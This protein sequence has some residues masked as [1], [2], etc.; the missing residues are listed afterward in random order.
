MTEVLITGDSHSAVMLRSLRDSGTAD[1]PFQWNGDTV[2]I[3]SIGPGGAMKGEFFENCGSYV[4]FV[5]PKLNTRLDR[6]PPKNSTVS[7]IGLS[8]PL[9]T[10][11]VWSKKWG[12]HAPTGVG[13]GSYVSKSAMRA[14]FESKSKYMF[15]LVDV[16]R[17]SVKVLVIE[18]PFPF[19]HHPAIEREG[20]QKVIHIHNTYR[21]YIMARLDD[22][23]IPVVTVEK[24]WLDPDG[25]MLDEFKS[26]DADDAVHGNARLGRLMLDKT[27][28]F[29]T[30]TKSAG[31]AA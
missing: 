1:N 4:R 28:E 24:D 29:L 17:A 12:N 30:A 16:L 7:L 19:R 25:F 27:L 3:R 6:L 5:N 31:E 8:G 11:W 9:T 22:A 2:T 18:P 13:S 15:E 14:I 20:F 26:D 23:G 10:I 21:D